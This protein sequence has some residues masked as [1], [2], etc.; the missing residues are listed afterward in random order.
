MY[1]NWCWLNDRWVYG[2][3]FISN[4]IAD[5][6]SRVNLVLYSNNKY[7]VHNMS[8]TI[9]VDYKWLH[10]SITLAA[11]VPSYQSHNLIIHS[12]CTWNIFVQ[13]KDATQLRSNL[14]YNLKLEL[15]SFIALI[16]LLHLIHFA[17]TAS[18]ILY[19]SNLNSSYQ[20]IASTYQYD[21]NM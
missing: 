8:T 21:L 1:T 5:I 3:I 15:S 18:Y 10:K 20:R 7:D 11:V 14:S 9:E 4:N 19:I 13:Q 2:T 12:K 16:L 17:P 6:V